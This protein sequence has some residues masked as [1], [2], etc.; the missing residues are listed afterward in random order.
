MRTVKLYF[1]LILFSL[2]SINCNSQEKKNAV[3]LELLGKSMYYFDISYERSLF[4]KF[5]L[6]A[7]FG[8]S[9][10]STLYIS[11]T[12]S[13]HELNFSIPLYGGL[14]FGKN[15]NHLIS[16]FGVTLMG[17]TNPDGKALITDQFPFISVGYERKWT[18]YFL[19]VPV[20]LGYIGSNEFFPAIMPW[21]G[22]SFGRLF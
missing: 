9:G 21:I 11:S 15:K 2:Y 14:N 1:I 5:Y 4:E 3:V 16:E 8:M 12:E 13:F 7:G 17:Q 10:I 20:Y 18:N 6:G 22:L 19:R